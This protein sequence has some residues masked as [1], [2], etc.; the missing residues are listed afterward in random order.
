[1]TDTRRKTCH[2]CQHCRLTASPASIWAY[3]EMSRGHLI[4]PHTSHTTKKIWDITFTGVPKFCPL[5]DTEV[6]AQ[7]LP[8]AKRDWQSL[9]IPK[10]AIERSPHEVNVI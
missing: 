9:T 2:D 8:A 5:P 10:N 6:R 3:C 4:V 7:V 1:M